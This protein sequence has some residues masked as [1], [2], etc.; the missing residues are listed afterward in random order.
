[1]SSHS[2]SI[3]LAFIASLCMSLLAYASPAIGPLEAQLMCAKRGVPTQPMTTGMLAETANEFAHL[4]RSEGRTL[5]CEVGNDVPFYVESLSIEATA[6]HPAALVIWMRQGI[7]RIID[8]ASMRFVVVHEIGH[9]T[10]PVGDDGVCPEGDDIA[11]NIACEHE[12][13]NFAAH[14]I[15]LDDAL[16]GL[17][18]GRSLLVAANRSTLSIDIIDERIRLLRAQPPTPH[19]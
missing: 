6:D 14:I 2:L 7:T 3:C 9:E 12:V 16:R 11:A 10:L 1:M 17:S 5:I 19:N 15:G 8:R 18:F 4:S 13:D